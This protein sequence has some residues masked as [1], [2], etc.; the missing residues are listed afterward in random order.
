MGTS[1]THR[2]AL[3]ALTLGAFSALNCEC[4]SGIERLPE[5]E[6]EVL[7]DQGN[8]HT[9][10]DPHLII[11]FGDVDAGGEQLRTL[12]IR[13]SNNGT[14]TLGN[15]CLVA[16]AALDDAIAEDAPC[17]QLSATAYS[18]AA[19]NGTELGE[20]EQTTLDIY[21]RPTEGGPQN[22][23]LRIESD[24]NTEPTV[25]VELTGRGT[26]GR[27]CTDDTVVDFGQVFVGETAT[28]TITLENCG[29]RPVTIDSFLMLQNPD[30]AFDVTYQGAAI[31]E[32]GPIEEGQSITLD[33]TFT[34]AQPRIY[35]DSLA[36]IAQLTSAEPFYGEYQLLLVGDAITPPSCRV[37]VVPQV[38]QYGAVASG[39]TVTQEI[40]VQSVGGCACQITSIGQPVPSDVGF[41]ITA[42]PTL[43]LTLSGNQG[44]EGDPADAATAPQLITIPVDYTAP[45]RATPM[46]DNAT[47]TVT[48]TD[49]EMPDRVVSLEANGGGTPFCQLDVTP[50]GGGF[51]GLP[52]I[53]RDGVAE[54]GRVT[55]YGAKNVPITLTNV[56]ND[57]CEISEINW[58]A[59][60]NTQLH[61]FD[62]VY[63]DGTPVNVGSVTPITLAPMASQVFYAR[64]APTHVIESSN[65]FDVFSF[66]SY[67][68]S[69]ELCETLLPPGP[70]TRC[71][72]VD[73]V[74]TDNTTVTE[75]GAGLFS[76][77]FQATP[78]EPAIDVIPGDLE[79][80]LVTLG[81]GSPEQRVTIYNT[82]SGDLVIDEPYIS[83]ANNPADFVITAVQNP[84]GTWPFTIAPGDQMGIFVRYYANAVGPVSGE[85]VIPTIEGNAE[86]PPVTVPLSGEGTLE[87]DQT[88]IFDQFNDPKV[89]V[90]FVVDDSGSMGPFQT[91]MAN[92]FSSFFVASN[93]SA[94]D[95][96]IAVTTTL[97]TDG[98]CIDPFGIQTCELHERCGWYSSCSGNDRFITTSSSNPQGQFQCNVQVSDNSN[99]NPSR[100]TSDSAEGAL[101]AARQFFENP[102]IDDPTING[103]F[104]RDDAKLHIILVSDEPDQSEGPVD[105]YVDFFRNIKGFRNDSLVA[106]SGIASPSGGCTMSDGTQLS[107]DARYETV[108]DEMGGRFQEICDADWT[109]MMQ[110]LGLD[111]L[112]L[113]IEFFLSRAADAATLDVCV[114]ENGAGDPV[115][116]PMTQTTDGDTSGYFYDPFSNSIVFNPLS[117]PERG[118]R[119]EVYYETFCY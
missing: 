63:E 108:V 50:V 89:D 19:L 83:P 84:S 22:L 13:N 42:M 117:V 92:N 33:V 74:T 73:F 23:F 75:N 106:V 102:N 81:C 80:G 59:A 8:S 109:T 98:N 68:A 99:R 49:E 11:A 24:A 38:L 21:F 113:Q 2:F 76:I 9:D 32:I 85:L 103:G 65:P 110:N 112:G 119:I 60:P 79:F 100:P 82:G 116:T 96:H 86:A 88:D 5:P 34:P 25:G 64:F 56:G 4:D 77:G 101:Q 6:I 78:V 27:L 87:T 41:E 72:G 111:S 28:Q 36:G 70:S 93:V 62:L 43:P 69:N 66:G 47:V 95:Y 107:G 67:S 44:C 53:G 71:N 48:V 114:R 15:I 46:T 58:S 54:F 14:L 104:L 7:D 31:T 10:A 105:L 1:R 90:L 39:N 55:I 20:G 115:C 37:N 97:T 18:F 57:F 52:A 61:E 3:L 91:Q 26:A 94:S 51:A 29:V 118:A 30:D 16:A 40:I 45:D 12:T 35:R 17:L